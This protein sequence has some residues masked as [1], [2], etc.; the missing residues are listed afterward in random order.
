MS[1]GVWPFCLM[2]GMFC[3]LQP[4]YAEDLAQNEAEKRGRGLASHHKPQLSFP[5]ARTT[6]SFKRG[7]FVLV[8][9]EETDSN[10]GT[11]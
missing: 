10:P 7:P 6:A 2:P 11:A 8:L 5:N 9:G 1:D 4:L 3:S